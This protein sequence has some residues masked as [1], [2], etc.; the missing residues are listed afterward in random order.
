MVV[1]GDDVVCAMYVVNGGANARKEE[2]YA[3]CAS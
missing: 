1:G 2:V 3:S